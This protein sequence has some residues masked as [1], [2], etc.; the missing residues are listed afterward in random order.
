MVD[1]SIPTQ[2]Q[3]RDQVDAKIKSIVDPSLRPELPHSMVG[4]FAEQIAVAKH[5]CMQ[6][7]RRSA[8][9]IFF[10]D[11]QGD[12]L[13][14]L[15][16]SFGVQRAPGTFAQGAIQIVFTT[17]THIDYGSTYTIIF[18]DP[19]GN[20]YR[21]AGTGLAT[22]PA[23]ESL[24]LNNVQTV[25]RGEDANIRAGVVLTVASVDYPNISDV[26][27]LEQQIRSPSVI[28]LQTDFTG[29][30]E[31]ESDDQ[32]RR[33]FLSVLKTPTAGGTVQEW[34]NWTRE[35]P[36]VTRVFIRSINAG[37]VDV[38]PIYDSQTNDLPSFEQLRIINEHLQQYRPAG[39]ELRVLAFTPV[40]VNIPVAIT[41]FNSTT[42]TAVQSAIIDSVVAYGALGK[43]FDRQR[44]GQALFSVPSLT[45][46]NLDLSADIV[47]PPNS[48][49]VPNVV[50]T[51]LV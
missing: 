48:L 4:A 42:R 49:F 44:I 33:R 24:I 45:R 50:I 5:T 27:A 10:A 3:E 11:A 39:T 13:D 28:S 25:A 41:P 22:S 2:Q 18:S 34:I 20:Q 40:N 17:A 35:I 47:V 8:Q 31:G 12:A 19:N 29:G 6:L 51:E 16:A 23:G 15:A 7:I 36:G 1:I 38:Y 30:V 46:F 43:N 26:P 9:A 37:T 14:S 21:A 32:L